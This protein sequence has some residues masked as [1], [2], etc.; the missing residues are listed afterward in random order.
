MLI[1]EFQIL[2]KLV[3]LKDMQAQ[4]RSTHRPDCGRHTE[5]LGC[6]IPPDICIVMAD[7]TMTAIHGLCGFP[8]RRTHAFNQIKQRQVALG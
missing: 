7:K 4:P 2:C 5:I 6:R 3:V 1:Q 8:S